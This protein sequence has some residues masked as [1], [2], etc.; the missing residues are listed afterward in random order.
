MRV[1]RI[2][3]ALVFFGLVGTL[4]PSGWAHETG[5]TREDYED[6]VERLERARRLAREAAH[7]EEHLAEDIAETRA[8]RRA[9][10]VELEELS[11]LVHRAEHRLEDAQAVLERTEAELDRKDAELQEALEELQATHDLVQERAVEVYKEGPASFVEFLLGAEDF[12]SLVTRFT[13]VRRV[14]RSDEERMVSL[15]RLKARVEAER[16]EVEELR[17]RAAEQVET[18]RA[19][20]N[21]VAALKGR[22]GSR[23]AALRAELDEL[24]SELDDVQTRKEQYLRQ[25]EELE[26]ESRRIASLLRGRSGGEATVGRGGMIWPASG[27][28]TSGYGWRTHPVF[29]TRRFHSGIDIGAPTGA[30]VRAS[31]TGTV[32]HAGAKGGYGNTVIVDHGGGVATL[33]G[34]LSSVRTSTG[35]TVGQGQTVGGVGCTGYCTGP[36]LHFEV[37]VNGEPQNPLQWLP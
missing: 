22:V 11:A 20:R 37:R 35:A 34:H 29:G 15:E 12:R 28:L 5:V 1:P 13:F 3:V 24:G 31:A 4:V 21:R 23:A 27:P 6:V 33:Y 30:P 25:Q 7:E 32:V 17:E 8:D 2:V 10:E 16:E 19:E 18:V 14:F 9:V 26:A 36:H